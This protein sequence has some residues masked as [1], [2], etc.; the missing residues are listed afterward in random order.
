MQCLRDQLLALAER[1]RV[2][3]VDELH[4][5]VDGMPEQ[6]DR[7]GGIGWGS[8]DVRAGVGA[9]AGRV[10]QS[11][12]A[13]GNPAH[14][15]IA[16]E[17][18][19]FPGA[20]CCVWCWCHVP[21]GRNCHQCHLQVEDRVSP[22]DDTLAIGELAGQTGVS[23]RSLRHYEQHDLLPA[24]R[25]AAGH[26]RFPADATETVRR[27]RMLLDGGLPLTIV[28]KIMPCFTDQGAGLDACVAGYLRDRLDTVAERIGVLDQ[29]RRTLQ[30]LRQLALA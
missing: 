8:P 21:H 16:A 9:V 26:R 2:G 15:Q 6:R 1:I 28:A 3:G 20:G 17:Q 27:I 13:Q 23:V 12:R 5:G 10:G 7:G 14:G 18:E 11:H 19:R 4:S 22:Y 30:S 29:Q 24:V 25:T